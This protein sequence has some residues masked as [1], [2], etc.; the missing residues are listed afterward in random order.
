MRAAPPSRA[1]AHVG[2][3]S[4]P[5]YLVR[6]VLSGEITAL[7][8]GREARLRAG[9]FTICDASRP[10]SVA[11]RESSDVLVVRIPRERLIQYVG[12]PEVVLSVRMPGDVGLSGLTSR[13]LRE[14]WS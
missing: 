7:Q 12:R 13:T 5:V 3:T 11:F 4:Q 1:P 8:E 9:D 10:Y 2:S 14:L 6:L